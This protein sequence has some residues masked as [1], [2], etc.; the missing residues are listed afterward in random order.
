MVDLIVLDQDKGSKKQI[1]PHGESG[2]QDLSPFNRP[3]KA[4]TKPPKKNKGKERG[5]FEPLNN[6]LHRE[7]RERGREGGNGQVCKGG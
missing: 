3:L 6:T 5:E 1:K 4:L 7:Q 2:P